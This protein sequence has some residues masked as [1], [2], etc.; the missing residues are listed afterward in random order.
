MRTPDSPIT[1]MT[2]HRN[3]DARWIALMNVAIVVVEFKNVGELY[4]MA[5]VGT[6]GPRK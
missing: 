5:F 6:E 4:G 2:R 3:P 1:M